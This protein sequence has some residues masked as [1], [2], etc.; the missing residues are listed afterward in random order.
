MLT[1]PLTGSSNLWAIGSLTGATQGGW[2]YDVLTKAGVSSS[3]AHSVVDFVLRP[4][5]VVVVVAVA[6]V[7]ARVGSRIIRR[8]L[9]RMAYRASRRSVSPRTPARTST[10]VALVA[11]LWRFFVAVVTFVI[12]LGML[13]LDLT[14][15]LASAT[16]IG[17]TI[18]FGAQSLVRDYL[19]GI[20]LAVEDQFGIGDTVEVNETTGVVEDLSLRVTR[21]RADDGTLWHLPNG[22]IRKLGNT[23]RGWARASVELPTPPSDAAE[24]ARAK[25]ILGD[26]AREVARSPRFVSSCTEPPEIM[27]IVAADGDSCTMRIALRTTP[28][29]RDPLERSLREAAVSHLVANGLWPQSAGPSTDGDA[30]DGAGPDAAAGAG[31]TASSGPRRP[32]S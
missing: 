6:I 25:D 32:G 19:S 5:E 28:E 3:T 7:V 26:A 4:V 14:P 24:L 15:L 11:N 10:A 18:G 9:G 31:P 12:V 17:A 1:P 29:H 16:V 2:L 23:S 20:L 13:G 8:H 27:G 21:V 22:D 30:A